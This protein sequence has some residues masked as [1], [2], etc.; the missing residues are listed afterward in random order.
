M[1]EDLHILQSLKMVCVRYL[2]KINSLLRA[3]MSL[4]YAAP[5]FENGRLIELALQYWHDLVPPRH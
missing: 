1:L 4:S 2:T 3:A 5:N